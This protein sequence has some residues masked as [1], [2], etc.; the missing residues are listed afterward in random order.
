MKEKPI[1]M[2]VSADIEG[3]SSGALYR[4]MK[5]TDPKLISNAKEL[6]GKFV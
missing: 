1:L 5:F 2:K 4:V 6:E 3:L